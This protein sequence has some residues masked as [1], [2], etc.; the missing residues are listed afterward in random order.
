[1]KG[2][3]F[4][5]R[6]FGGVVLF[7]ALH[8]QRANADGHADAS[9]PKTPAGQVTPSTYVKPLGRTLPYEPAELP[10]DGYHIER[11]WQSYLVIPSAVVLGISYS[12]S[13]AEAVA[14]GFRGP[15]GYLAIPL[16]GPF[17]TAFTG[18]AVITGSV[19]CNSETLQVH[20]NEAFYRT[21]LFVDGVAQVSSAIFLLATIPAPRYVLVSDPYTREPRRTRLLLAPMPVSSGYGVRVLGMF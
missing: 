12:F 8:T 16:G 10:P 4:S 3:G 11:S 13:F 20:G 1:M 18:H 21:L 5:L 9:A 14:V 6:T 7:G 19:C 2:L 17:I 15:N